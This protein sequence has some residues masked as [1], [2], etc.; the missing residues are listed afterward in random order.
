MCLPSQMHH[1]SIFGEEEDLEEEE[2]LTELTELTV[3]MLCWS[4]QQVPEDAPV[5]VGHLAGPFEPGFAYRDF[6]GDWMAGRLISLLQQFPGDGQ[7]DVQD[8][9]GPF[10]DGLV[11]GVWVTHGPISLD[12]DTILECYVKM[13]EYL[14]D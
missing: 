4:L 3:D 11:D 10:E 12:T 6:H 2:E 14:Y 9:V 5:S 7:V 1:L 13:T 8:L